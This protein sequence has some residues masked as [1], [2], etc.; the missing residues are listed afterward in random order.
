MQE[1]SISPNFEFLLAHDQQL[2]R[3][4]YLAERYFSEDPSTSLIKM[5]QFGETLAQLVAA[6][7][8][9]Y[10]DTQEAQTDVIRRLKLERVIPAEVGELF[11]H[12]RVAG[13]RATHEGAGN[14]GE[15]LTALKIGRQLGIWF[16]RTFGAPKGFAPVAFTPPADPATATNELAAELAQLRT[17]LDATRTAAERARAV[18]EE[19]AKARLSAEDERAVWEQLAAEAEQAKAALATELQSLQAEAVAAPVPVVAAIVAKAQTA[20]TELNIDEAS[21]RALIDEQ[22]RARGWAADTQTLRYSRGARPAKGHNFAIAEWPTKSGPVDYA[23]FLGTKCIAV[24][25]AKRRNKNVSSSIDQAQRYARGFRFEVGAEPIGGPYEEEFLVPYVFSANGRPYLAQVETESGIWFRDTRKA[26]N[27]RRVLVDWPTPDGLDA[28]L[29]IDTEAADAQLK[30]QAFHFGFPLRPYQQTAIERVEAELANGRRKMLLAMATGTGKT[31]LA[32]AMLYRLLA[33]KRFR[34]ICFVVDRHA[35]GTQAGGEFSTT[36]IVSGKTF[37]DIFGLKGLETVKPDP[38]TRVHICTIQGLVKRVLFTES[39]SDSPP[40]D[41]YD[42]MVVDECHRGYL[43]DRELSD[44]ELSFR[45]Q[46]D[47]ISKYRRVLD[48]FDSVKIGLTATPALHTAA[49]FGKPIYQYPYREAV[50]D[51]YLIDHE[52]PVQITTA[53]SKAGIR[54]QKGEQIGMLDTHTGKVDLAE[55]PDEIHFGGCTKDC[56]NAVLR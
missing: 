4:G 36:R 52:P 14:H 22:L 38:E 25:E 5:R 41:Q 26:S 10:R 1:R 23:L 34:R 47:Y 16:H 17:E 46:E 12:L 21:T 42:L 29:G 9:M 18:A 19:E 28:M 13:N 11:H 45:N 37:A 56:V 51:G 3:L 30:K 15:A 40:V 31:K 44:A 43:L 6:R 50:I 8:G 27:L 2:V 24:V 35:L 48:H 32:I 49:I 33:A 55:V 39:V 54:F 53:L 20:A 7:A